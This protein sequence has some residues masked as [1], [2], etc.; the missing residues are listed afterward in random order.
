[1]FAAWKMHVL[2]AENWLVLN[3]VGVRT[4]CKT[5]YKLFTLMSLERS[6]YFGWPYWGRRNKDKKTSELR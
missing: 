4:L 3:T 5:L 2:K 6:G 1:M